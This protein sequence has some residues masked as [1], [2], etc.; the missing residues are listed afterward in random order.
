MNSAELNRRIQNGESFLV[1]NDGQY[2]GK[3]TL[4]RFDAESVANKFGDYGSRFSTVSI[5]NKFNNY[6]SRFSSLSPFN[7]FTSTPPTI[8]LQG[9]KHGYLT[10][11]RFVAG[12]QKIDPDELFD[13]LEKKGLRF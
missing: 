10:K 1:A 13:W 11:N 2:L 5:F 4:N 8:Y 12:G 9:S 6:G 3:L 7:K